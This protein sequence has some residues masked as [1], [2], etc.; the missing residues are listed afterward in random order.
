LRSWVE[1]RGGTGFSGQEG[2]AVK[3]RMKEKGEGM[4]RRR[5]KGSKKKKRCPFRK[6]EFENSQSRCFTKGGNFLKIGVAWR[7]Q[8]HEVEG[9]TCRYF[10]LGGWEK[11]PEGGGVAHFEGTFEE[12]KVRTS[13]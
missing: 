10:V 1:G 11:L 4:S 2:G 9:Q 8:T 5:T 6:R 12:K 7:E 3:R 13:C